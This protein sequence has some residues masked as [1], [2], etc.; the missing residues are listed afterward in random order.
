MTD[1]NEVYDLRRM[2][3]VVTERLKHANAYK[4]DESEEWSSKETDLFWVK[5]AEELI[6]RRPST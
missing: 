3:R 2:L 1:P 6:W 5:R 4:G